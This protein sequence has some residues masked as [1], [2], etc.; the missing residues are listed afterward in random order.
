MALDAPLISPID[1]TPD[2]AE[3]I[4]DDA[5]RVLAVNADDAEDLRELG[6][7]L[8][9]FEASGAD[10]VVATTPWALDDAALPS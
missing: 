1:T 5:R 9:L 6:L 10:S 8:G 7:M 3:R 4:A 2:A